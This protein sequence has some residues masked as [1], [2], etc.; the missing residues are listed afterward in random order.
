LWVLT[1]R[2]Y[3]I[4]IKGRSQVSSLL[5]ISMIWSLIAVPIAGGLAM[6]QTV[7]LILKIIFLPP[8]PQKMEQRG[9]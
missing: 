1:E 4:A 6:L 5:D 7:F 9:N 3:E 8:A 2:G